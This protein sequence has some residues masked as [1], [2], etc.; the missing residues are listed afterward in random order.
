MSKTIYVGMSADLVHPGHMN[1]IKEA[2][3]LGD[4]TIGLLTDKAIASYKRLPYM[5]YEQRKSVI[6]NIKG[7]VKVVPQ[8]TLDYRPNLEDIKPDI[9][10]HGDDWKE[11]VQSKTRQQVIDALAQW[12]GE[13]VEIGYTE[14]ISSTQLNNSLKELGTTADIRRSRLRRL[15][16]AKP[17]VRIMESH[18]AL[19]GLIVEN[20]KSDDG[21]EYDGMWSSSLTDSTS[22]GKPDIEA[23]DVSTRITT[24]NE[25][26]EVTTKPMIYDADTGGIAEHFVF[27]V[28]TLERT[29]ISA[30]IIEDK[31]GLKKNSLFGNDVSQTQDTIENFCNKIK[32]GKAAQI[33]DDFMVISRIESL[34]LE[35]GMDDAVARAKAYIEAGTDGI[36]IHSRQKSPDEV[37]EFCKILRAYNEHIPIIVVPTSY[38]QIT[39]KELSEA[40]INVVIYANHML[41]AAYPG[42][43]NVAKSI[44]DNDRSMEAEENLLSIKKILDLIPGTR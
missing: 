8:D 21:V 6:E 2:A 38:N 22:K 10:V 18:N 26:F 34:I 40:G 43:M 1:I 37:L 27:T 33:T 39:A 28:R 30:V 35:A 13:L 15:I 14:G 36:M 11:G 42:M 9:V 19:S 4:L 5:A 25:I 3:K 41:R 31:T 20:V 7:V 23:V 17:V 24:I 12:G 32:M 44:L 29:G 16:D